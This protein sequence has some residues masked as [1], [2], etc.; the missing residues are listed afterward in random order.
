M[1][2]HYYTT[3]WEDTRTTMQSSRVY[4]PGYMHMQ[5]FTVW[6]APAGSVRADGQVSHTGHVFLTVDQFTENGYKRS[7]L[8]F[9]PGA[10]W[11]SS[12]DNIS[13]NDVEMYPGASSHTY[14]SNNSNFN[15][16]I[17]SLMDTVNGYANGSLLPPDYNLVTNNCIDFVKKVLEDASVNL[18]LEETPD[19]VLENL[20]AIGDAYITPIAIDLDGNGVKTVS[21]ADGVS[22]DFDGDGNVETAGWIDR[23]DGLLAMDRNGNGTIDNGGELFGQNSRLANGDSAQDGFQALAELDSNGDG[24]INASDEAWAKLV[25][26]QDAN[27]DGVSAQDELFTLDSLGISEISLSTQR[28]SGADAAG[29]VHALQST[30]SWSNGRTTSAVDVL[31]RA[32]SQPLPV[33]DAGRDFHMEDANDAWHIDAPMATDHLLAVA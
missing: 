18:E 27:Q 21:H 2:R 10:D 1:A 7:S 16:S 6:T 12:L 24:V 23:G 8:G 17:Q 28:G 14:S 3:M 32:E 30:V 25:V 11:N 33:E 31:L 9:S 26:W 29:N 13:F 15:F 4:G 19:G 22:F 20:E 5:S